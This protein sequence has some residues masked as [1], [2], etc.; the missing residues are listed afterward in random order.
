MKKKIKLVMSGSGVKFCVFI[1]ALRRLEQEPNYDGLKAVAGTSG[2]GI[3]AAALASGYKDSYELEKMCK[4]FLP[5]ANKIL[6]PSLYNFIRHFGFYKTNKLTCLF[7]QYLVEKMGEA[8]I[9]LKIITTNIDNKEY[10]IAKAWSSINDPESNV[11]LITTATMSIPFIF[12]YILI[13]ENR[14]IDGGW[15]KNFAIDIYGDKE[16]VIGLYF[17]ASFSKEKKIPWYRPVGRLIQYI[18]RLVNIAII[19][20]MEESIEEAKNA[21]LIKLTSDFNGM[22]F[23]PSEKDIDTMIQDGWKSVDKFL[24]NN[25][26]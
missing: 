14:Y 11:A 13:E 8:K 7:E 1:G 10:K 19:Q 24:K 21:K 9:P 5:Q 20:N 12:P 18:S 15:V 6:K 16:D 3:I 23:F 4:E 22:N 17:G 2:G 25:K 26:I